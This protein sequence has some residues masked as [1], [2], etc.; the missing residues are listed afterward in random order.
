MQ[1]K[2]SC[3]HGSGVAGW[4]KKH[5]DLLASQHATSFVVLCTSSRYCHPAGQ[6]TPAA[7]TAKRPTVMPLQ[8]T[9]RQLPLADQ[10]FRSLWAS[11]YHE[12]LQQHPYQLAAPC[13]QVCPANQLADRK[14]KICSTTD[15]L[16]WAQQVRRFLESRASRE[17]VIGDK[18]IGRP[19]CCASASVC[20]RAAPPAPHRDWGHSVV[21]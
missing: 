10:S 19:H 4:G 17:E 15:K 18:P 3:T 5:P 16:A 13:R 1:D 14:G 9:W 2:K 8:L 7:L 12:Q 6:A 21:T 20:V 11:E